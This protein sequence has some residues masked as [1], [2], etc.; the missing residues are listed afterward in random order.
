MKVLDARGIA[1]PR[2]VIMAKKAINDEKLLEIMVYVD[3]EIATQNLSKMGQQLGF[4]SEVKMIS[5]GN[6]E[7]VLKKSDNLECELMDLED[8][9]EYIVVISSDYMGRGDEDFSKKLLE[10]FI[11]ALREQDVLPKFVVFYNTGIRLTTINTKTIEDLKF[12]ELKGTTI[13]SCGLCLD[14]Y[15]LKEKLAV[16]EATNMY[17]ICELQRMYKTV[18]PC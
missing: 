10:G 9:S 16:G 13:L 2:P 15:N 6:Y 14:N 4:I 12:M 11:Y 8:D 17:R 1:C 5:D 7:V 18:T 3:N